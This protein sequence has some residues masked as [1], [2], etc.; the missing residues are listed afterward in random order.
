MKQI[1]PDRLDTLGDKEALLE[2]W[3]FAIPQGER[4][5]GEGQ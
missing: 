2:T 3:S 5:P 4:Q 1:H